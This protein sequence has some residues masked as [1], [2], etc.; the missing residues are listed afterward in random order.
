MRGAVPE[1]YDRT[2][3]YKI[4]IAA[5]FHSLIAGGQTGQKSG[6]ILVFYP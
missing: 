2:L 6:L 3:F 1:S 4:A 5:F